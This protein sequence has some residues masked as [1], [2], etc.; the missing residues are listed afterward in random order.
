MQA[1]RLNILTSINSQPLRIF[2]DLF[3]GL[4]DES[5]ILA[6]S[7]AKT[8]T[9]LAGDV[10]EDDTSASS[11][12]KKPSE[13]R[14]FFLQQFIPYL[15]KSLS[16]TF[17][18][19][20]VISAV[21]FSDRVLANTILDNVVMV[22]SA[23]T[24]QNT[25]DYLLKILSPSND[26]GYI[27]FPS[28]DSYFFLYP[29]SS[30]TPPPNI[31]LDDNTTLIWERYQEAPKRYWRTCPSTAVLQSGKLYPID[32]VNLDLSLLEWKP[33]SSF[34]SAVPSSAFTPN[35]ALQESIDVF[36]RLK[37]TA[38]LVNSFK[39]SSDE[40]IYIIENNKDFADMQ[41]NTLSMAQ[42]KRIQAYVAFRDSLPTTTTLPLIGLFNWGSQPQYSNVGSSTLAF[43]IAQA[44][45]WNQT[46]IETILARANNAGSV[47][48]DFVNEV[49]LVKIGKLLALSTKLGVD[50]TRLFHWAIPF[51]TSSKDFFKLNDVSQDIQKVVHSKFDAS[52][53]NDAVRPLNDTL[54]GQRQSALVAYLLGMSSNL[55]F[56]CRCSVT[57]LACISG[58]EP[59]RFEFKDVSQC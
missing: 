38:I 33:S 20:T 57:T 41:F 36:D 12:S 21:G 6:E 23:G 25:L 18:S 16:R 59:H 29:D 50:V 39:L 4:L 43:Q 24:K 27:T 15:Q 37:K 35:I 44:T 45:N 34:R 42:W 7:N 26:N 32:F 31:T 11:D 54:R 8:A 13:K 55:N 56:H 2:D 51:G 19:D 52:S 48:S 30:D 5:A 10:P 28:N 14:F 40:V 22:D 47:G 53:W 9:I 17:A 46:T 3:T 1:R 58:S 49:N